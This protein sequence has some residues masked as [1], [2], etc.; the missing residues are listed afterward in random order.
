MQ[1]SKA[2]REFQN[3]PS[4]RIIML[5]AEDSVSGLNFTQANYVV[6]FHPFSLGSNSL[7]LD[8]EKQGIARAWR[9]G[10]Q[11][12]V[13]VVRFFTRGTMEESIA[14]RRGFPNADSV[15]Q[16]ASIIEEVGSN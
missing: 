11:R 14:L 4:M 10:Q 15:K 2:V 8:Y 3:D 7:A 6:V 1:R 9:Y 12:P 16:Y 13:N 5:S